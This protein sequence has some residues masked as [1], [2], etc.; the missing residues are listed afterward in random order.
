[1]QSSIFRKSSLE[2]ISSPEQLNEYVRIINPGVWLVLLGLLALLTAGAIWAYTGSIP[3]TLPLTGVVFA[4][5]GS[6]MAV[7]SFVPMNASRRLALG[8]EV[9][10][11]PDYAPRQEYGYILGRVASIGARP[12][13]VSELAET[14]GD[15]QYVQQLLAEG[16]MVQVLVTLDKADGGLHWSSKRG[17]AV[18]VTSGSYCDLLVVVRARK[19]YELLFR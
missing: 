6:D 2:R 19:P 1:M 18:A 8:M 14:F 11:S 7:Y 9:Q 12:V 15:A 5:G 17:E 4:H 13:T 10:V 16:S 3:E